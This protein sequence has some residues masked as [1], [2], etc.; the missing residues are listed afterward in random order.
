MKRIFTSMC[1]VFMLIFNGPT[2]SYAAGT[3]VDCDQSP[4]FTKRLNASV[5]KLEGRL[6]KYEPGS[7]PALAL[8]QQIDR[9]K[10]ALNVMG[11]Q[12]YCVVL[13]VYHI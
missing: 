4:A 11:N 5:K 9:T 13:T 7:P 3:L 1:I 12:I 10:H 2:N 6:S 8:Q